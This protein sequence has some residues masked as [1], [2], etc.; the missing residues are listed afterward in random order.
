MKVE[1]ENKDAYFKPKLVTKKAV[2]TRMTE[3]GQNGYQKYLER[4]AYA[5][6]LKDEIK[7][8]EK[9]VFLNGSNWNPK[10]T[11]PQT[12]RLAYIDKGVKSLEKPCTTDQSAS[13]KS[14]Y[15]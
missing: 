6:S 1:E 12:P 14:L 2:E 9:K 10:L 11:H 5:R 15:T 8:K 13:K 4:T 3:S 7:Y